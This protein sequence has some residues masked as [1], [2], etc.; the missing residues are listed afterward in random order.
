MGP[1]K[2]IVMTNGTEEGGPGGVSCA[3]MEKSQ[4]LHC[5]CEIIG[6]SYSCLWN[7]VRMARLAL[8]CVMQRDHAEVMGG[9]FSSGENNLS[10]LGN[11]HGCRSKVDGAAISIE[12][13]NRNKR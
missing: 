12:F 11:V 2:E 10:I 8:H 5:S 1:T 7:H 6:I 4:L 9:V 13:R 3:D